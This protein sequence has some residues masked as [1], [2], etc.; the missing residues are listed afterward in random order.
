MTKEQVKEVL[1][2]VLSWSPQRQEEAAELLKLIEQHDS[3]P[4]GLS[5]EQAAELRER[6]A[7]EN[8]A[9]ISLTELDQ[10]LRRLGV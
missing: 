1:D 3:S 8:P 5:E 4:M 9:T 10:R 2:R 6:L 7:E